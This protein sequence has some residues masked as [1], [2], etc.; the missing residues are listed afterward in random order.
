MIIK[1]QLI[2][3]RAGYPIAVI[4]KDDRFRYYDALEISQASDLS[5]F[6]SLLSESIAE[7][8]EEYEEAVQEQRNMQEWAESLASKFT[9][10]ERIK[11]RNDFEVWINAMELLK[12][13]FRQVTQT[14]N[15]SAQIGHISFRDFGTLEYEKYM[16]L[17]S[18]GQAKRTWFFRIDFRSGDRS[19]RYLFFFGVTSYSM[20]QDCDV[21]LHV[22][23]EEPASSFNY[24]RLD[25]IGAPNV[26]NIHELG[27]KPD[28]ERFVARGSGGNLKEAKLEKLGRLF[29]KEVIDKHFANH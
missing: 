14:I 24:E 23:R 6:T 11:A 19:A 1:D 28:I 5:A 13:Y 20:K 8:L 21:T 18:G 26:P 9:E 16:S 22:A 17:R 7:S 12:S 29:F 4:T 2:L 3:M 25:N 10:K 15:D 27:Y